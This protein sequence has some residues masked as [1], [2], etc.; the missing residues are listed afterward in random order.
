[1]TETADTSGGNPVTVTQVGLEYLYDTGKTIADFQIG[2]LYIIRLRDGRFIIV[3][4]GYRRQKNL[5]LFMDQLKKQAPDP[6]NIKIAAWILTHS[7]GDHVGLLSQV[8]NTPSALKC[9]SVERFIYNFPSVGQYKKMEESYP[10]GVYSSIKMFRGAKTVKAH[11]GQRFVIGGAE[12]EYYSTVELVAPADCDTGNT[13]SAVFSLTAE[14][15]KI[16]FLGDSS[17]TMTNVLVKCYGKALASDIVQVAHH[18]AHGGSVEL[19]ENIDMKVAL[20][21]LGV[22]DY[23]NYGGHGRKSET[24]NAYFYSSQKMMEIILAGHSERTITLPY[25]PA[26]KRFPAD[27]EADY[28]P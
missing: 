9:L 25:E 26:A 6:Q 7:H 2:M 11:P 1:M 19:Y 21:P 12:I 17:S 27:K 8:A 14:G 22:W 5:E 24:W 13:V 28:T 20:W 23:Y 18:G 10:G 4:G 3:D 16:M 15:Q